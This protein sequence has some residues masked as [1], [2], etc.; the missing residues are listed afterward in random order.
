MQDGRAA[1]VSDA[2]AAAGRADLLLVHT[3][4]SQALANFLVDAERA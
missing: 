3:I 1:R 4:D 2:V